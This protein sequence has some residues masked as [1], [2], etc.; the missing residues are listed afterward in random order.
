MAY[1]LRYGPALVFATPNLADN[2]QPLLLIVQGEKFEFDTDVEN[3][4]REMTQR[5]AA[6]PVGQAIV[7][8][9]MMQLFFTRVLGIRPEL[10]GWRRGS[11]KRPSELWQGNGVAA[12]F[13]SRWLFGPIAAAFGPVEAQGRGSLRPHILVWLLL[14]ELSDLLAWLLRDR[15]NFK[16][17]LNLWMRELI[18][19]VASV[20]ESAVTQLPQ[21]L[22]PG[23]PS[24]APLLV[25]PLPLG[26]NERQRYHADG[27]VETATA[28][29]LGIENKAE[30]GEENEHELYYYV[31]KNDPETA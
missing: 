22:Q 31:P 10:I 18:A 9:E 3:N 25:P 1:T 16:E 27:G 20:Q 30:D 13:R 21:T 29:E 4:Y 2:K 11:V 12:D 6:D 24:C 17:R 23:R 8:E 19:S 14:T 28:E 5:L 7:F 15:A 26:P